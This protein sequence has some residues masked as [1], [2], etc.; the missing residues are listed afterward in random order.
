[1]QVPPILLISYAYCCVF[2][3]YSVFLLPVLSPS[4]PPFF[5]LFSHRSTTCIVSHMYRISPWNLL[6]A[7]RPAYKKKPGFF[8]LA[9]FDSSLIF[10]ALIDNL[11]CAHLITFH[12]Y[13]FLFL[14]IPLH[15]S[16][17]M[18]NK[19]FFM[20]HVF[21]LLFIFSILYLSFFLNI[22][23]SRI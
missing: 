8:A 11:C 21:S 7:G 3:L 18:Q 5:H 2:F 9:S 19:I 10:V 17:L 13:I 4:L 23:F 20:S 6:P 16:Y 1:M 12:T 22:S 15:L 14:F